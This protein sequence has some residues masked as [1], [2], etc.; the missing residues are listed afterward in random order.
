MP[1]YKPFQH[2][3]WNQPPVVEV[4]GHTYVSDEEKKRRDEECKKFLQEK[5][6][7]PKDEETQ[8]KNND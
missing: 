1:K 7:I 3:R 5:G 4:I 8:E 6:I 2:P